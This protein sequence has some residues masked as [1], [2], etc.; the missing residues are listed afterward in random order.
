MFG[1]PLLLAQGASVRHFYWRIMSKMI[2][3]AL[4]EEKTEICWR[5][6]NGNIKI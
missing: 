5:K 6:D 1:P 3:T 2:V 4:Y